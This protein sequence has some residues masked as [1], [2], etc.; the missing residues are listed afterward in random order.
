[1]CKNTLCKSP[2]YLPYSIGI[3]TNTDF[4]ILLEYGLR[5]PR[6]RTPEYG[7]PYPYVFEYGVRILPVYKNTDFLYSLRIL[8][9]IRR[10]LRVFQNAALR[11]LHVF[12]YGNCILEVF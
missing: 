6:M 4:R 12:L 8:S 3:R 2:Y 7:I 1:M 11:I 9:R 10:I 5:I